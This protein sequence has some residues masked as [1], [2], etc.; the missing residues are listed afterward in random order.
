[1]GESPHGK[2]FSLRGHAVESLC[3]NAH[4]GANQIIPFN[5]APFAHPS[6]PSRMPRASL[7]KHPGIVH[8]GS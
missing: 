8:H 4:P 2:E 3:V 7:D 1:M 6:M 5:A